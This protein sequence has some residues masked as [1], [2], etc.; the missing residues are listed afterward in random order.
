MW[1]P[2]HTPV[3]N[4]KAQT[5]LT[6]EIRCPGIKDSTYRGWVIE[7]MVKLKSLTSSIATTLNSLKSQGLL[8]AIW[9]HSKLMNRFTK[10][11]TD[12]SPK[13]SSE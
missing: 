3:L 11:L 5:R 9:T 10:L 1:M 13:T 8:M 4:Q 6:M 2:N 12:I 7:L